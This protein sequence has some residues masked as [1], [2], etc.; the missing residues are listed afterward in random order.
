MAV[1]G[2]FDVIDTHN[3]KQMLSI[4]VKDTR[5]NGYMD[6]VIVPY[7]SGSYGQD[8]RVGV[9]LKQSPSDKQRYDVEFGKC[10]AATDTVCNAMH[11]AQACLQASL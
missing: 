3:N 4:V 10:C 11:S 8:M 5:Y 6:A 9:E 1:A 7:G 2:G